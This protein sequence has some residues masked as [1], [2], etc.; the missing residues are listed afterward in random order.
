MRVRLTHDEIV[1]LR[2][3]SLELL[4]ETISESGGQL[5]ELWSGSKAEGVEGPY[6]SHG[7]IFYGRLLSELAS[8]FYLIATFG[9]RRRDIRLKGA[10]LLGPSDLRFFFTRREAE[11]YARGE[12]LKGEYVVPC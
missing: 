9:G 10:G 3:V 1:H 7:A 2:P 12:V 11:A 5:A 6:F 8:G 4:L